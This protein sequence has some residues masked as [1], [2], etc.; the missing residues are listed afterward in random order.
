MRYTK[1]TWARRGEGKNAEN[2]AQSRQIQVYANYTN[3]EK[4][5]PLVSFGQQ[6]RAIKGIKDIGHQTQLKDIMQRFE[7]YRIGT[8]RL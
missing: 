6:R 7:C 5:I 4:L 1:A 8:N 2:E 3:L